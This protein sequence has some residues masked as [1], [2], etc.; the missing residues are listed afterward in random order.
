MNPDDIPME[1]LEETAAGQ[2][3][4]FSELEEKIKEATEAKQSGVNPKSKVLKKRKG[5]T[6]KM[7][8]AFNAVE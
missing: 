6:G 7:D 1:W 4:E 8:E 2:S 5:R 3:D